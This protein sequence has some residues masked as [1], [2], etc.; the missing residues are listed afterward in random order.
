MAIIR[1]R[2]YDIDPVI[3][4][5]LV[6]GAMVLL[7]FVG[8]VGVVVGLGAL[9]PVSDRVLAL[10]ATAAVAVVFEPVRRRAQ[11]LAD[12]LVYGRRATPYETLRPRW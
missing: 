7:I 12:R 4:K 10:A 5:T 3:N 9:L 2:L 1:Y 8:Y 6:G 11:A